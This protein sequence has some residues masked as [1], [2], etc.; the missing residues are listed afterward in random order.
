MSDLAERATESDLAGRYHRD[1][2][3]VLGQALSAAEVQAL[4]QEA[5]RI[6]RGELGAVDGVQRAGAD[7][8]D[9]LVVR[10]YLCIHFPHKVS[11][12]M[13]GMLAHPAIV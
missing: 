9:A 11:E 1:G 12:L 7:E 8:P 6:C 3:V 13:G 4:R 5:V 10:R 2:Y